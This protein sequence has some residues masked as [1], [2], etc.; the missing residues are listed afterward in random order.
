MKILLTGASGFIGGYFFKEK[1]KN[2][3]NIKTF[4]FQN[5]NFDD[6][7]LSDIDVVVHLSALVHQMQGAKKELYENINVNNTIKLALKAKNIGVKHFIFMSTIKVYGEES[8]TIYNEFTECKPRDNYGQSKLKA[9]KELLKIETNG[10]KISIIRTPIVYGYEVKGNIQSLIKLI[11][12]FNI[13]PFKDINNKRSM[14][15][16]GNLSY[17]IYQIIIQGK[18]GVFLASD[19]EVISTSEF[20]KLIAKYLNKNLYLIKIP[21]F[22]ICLKILKKS[23]YNRLYGSLEIDNSFTVTELNLKNPY[24]VED[25]IKFMIKGENI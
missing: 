1:Y 18:R 3:F 21:F 17:L 4:S 6:L 13:L 16:V 7:D 23:F 11:S 14:V 20:M 12:K 15:Y 22:R 2:K 9:E 10:F 24:S 25:G 8:N 5:D 19:T